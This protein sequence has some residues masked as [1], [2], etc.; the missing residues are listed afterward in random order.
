MEINFGSGNLKLSF[1]MGSGGASASST[2]TFVS[3]A[4][5][6][7]GP[8][9][10]IE[11]AVSGSWVNFYYQRD[12]TITEYSPVFSAHYIG[13]SNLTNFGKKLWLLDNLGDRISP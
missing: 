6:Q 4:D 3:L 8:Q 13:N 11:K 2:G 7:F 9:L 1:L 10:D 5:P 12:Q